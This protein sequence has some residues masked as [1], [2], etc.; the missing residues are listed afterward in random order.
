MAG[1]LNLGTV[2]GL[3]CEA[4]GSRGPQPWYFILLP[5]L[6]W[7]RVTLPHTLLRATAIHGSGKS[8]RHTGFYS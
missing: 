1:D 8:G 2:A 6:I 7:S 5:L 3:A 4:G